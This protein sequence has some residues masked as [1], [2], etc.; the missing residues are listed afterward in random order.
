MPLVNV[1]VNGRAYTWSIG[2]EKC[3]VKRSG[4][5]SGAGGAHQQIGRV[6]ARGRATPKTEAVLCR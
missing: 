6:R 5:P 3:E 4:F 1:M 2:Q